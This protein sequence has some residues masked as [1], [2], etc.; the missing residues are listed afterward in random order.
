MR[1]A[2]Q[3]QARIAKYAVSGRFGQFAWFSVL[4]DAEDF[5]KM[6]PTPDRYEIVELT[7]G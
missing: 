2:K 4:F 3:S 5:V 7:R 6:Q 1:T